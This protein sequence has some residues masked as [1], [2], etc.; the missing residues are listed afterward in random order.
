MKKG[1][2]LFIVM[3]VVGVIVL[4]LG[5][6]TRGV[7]SVVLGVTGLSIVV[8]TAWYFSERTSK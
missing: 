3:E 4:S 7:I 1:N 6:K 5:F 2:L 8:M